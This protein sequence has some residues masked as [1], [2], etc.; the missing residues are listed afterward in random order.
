MTKKEP[1]DCGGNRILT[2]QPPKRKPKKDTKKS[3]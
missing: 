3:K 1:S 2:I